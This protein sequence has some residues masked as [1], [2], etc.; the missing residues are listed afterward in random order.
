[1]Y[2]QT[3]SQ[4]SRNVSLCALLVA[5]ASTLR[6]QDVTGT[7]LNIGA[8]HTLSGTLSTIA[9]G[10]TNTASTNFATV[11][12]GK[13]NAATAPYSFIGGGA[14]NSVSESN[15][16]VAGGL[17]NANSGKYSVAVGGI[18]HQQSDHYSFIG[19]GF[20]NVNEAIYGTIPG[21]YY[22]HI[23]TNTVETGVLN[24]GLAIVIGGGAF[25]TNSGTFGT[26]AGGAQNRV[27]NVYS[28]VSGGIGNIGGGYANSIGGGQGNT[29]AGIASFI[30]GGEGNSNVA[31]DGAIAG[32]LSNLI[33]ANGSGGSI[34]GGSENQVTAVG[35]TVPGGFG[36]KASRYGQLAY[37][38]GYFTSAGD[39]QASLYVLRKTTTTSSQAELFLD[40]SSQR[41]TIPSGSSWTFD[42]LIVGRSS[43]NSGGYRIVGLIENNGGTTSFV[44]TP[45]VTT[46]GEDVGSWDAIAVADTTNDALTVKVTGDNTSVRWVATVRTAEV[47]N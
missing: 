16:V 6:S 33:D 14:F 15:S 10:G 22:N 23:R 34:G 5:S 4:W 8:N 39:A 18:L 47:I 17:S 43:S 21:G 29:T 45:T 46:L 11:S 40:G 7:R 26:I 28:V 31:D 19:G 2:S 25:N 13:K 36:G 42:I 20:Q 3:L 30:G 1:M 38:S 37:G 35:G 44:G 9:G 27:T 32:G 41:M 24:H 12:G